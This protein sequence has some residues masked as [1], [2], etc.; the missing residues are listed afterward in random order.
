MDSAKIALDRLREAYQKHVNGTEDV[1]E[2]FISKYEKDFNEAINDDLNMPVAMS[3]VWEVAK[4]TEKSKKLA[5]LLK[6][7]DKVLGIK[8]DEYKKEEIPDEIKE[9]LTKRA[10]ARKNKAW[11]ESD[12]IRDIIK[13]KG[14]IV[15][16]SKEGQ[17]V[18]KI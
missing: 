14:Y 15:K 6:K 13:E 10:E 5:E 3:V 18:E 11:A 9:L 12:K 4:R 2:E 8:I 16:D 1:A 7:F 17:T